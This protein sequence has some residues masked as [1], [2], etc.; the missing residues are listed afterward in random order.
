MS[1]DKKKS[2]TK[3]S[4]TK[5]SVTPTKVKFVV[6]KPNLSNIKIKVKMPDLKKMFTQMKESKTS[7]TVL[8]IVALVLIVVGSFAL[9]DLGV[10]YLNNDYSVAIV[11]GTRISKSE[12]NKLLQQA[13]GQAGATQLIDNEVIAQEAKKAEITASDEEIQTQVDQ[14]VTSLGGQTEYEAALKANNLTD[15]ELKKE[16]KLDILTTKLLTPTITYTDDDLK[17]F[18]TQYSAQMFPT[19]TAALE[20]GAKLDFDTYKAQT[21]TYYVQ[22]QVSNTKSTWLASKEAEYKIQN[23]ATSKPTYGLFGTTI[24]IFKN[25]TAK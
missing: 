6:K 8:K 14:I 21:T 5:A 16:I 19:E 12:W 10:Q 4:Q 25:L 3:K 20:T 18:F 24:N 2:P 1:K 23:N 15:T 11:N 22:Q 13:Y 7:K 9:I 17:S